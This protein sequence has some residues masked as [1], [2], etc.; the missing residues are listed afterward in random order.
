[1]SN[2]SSKSN[3]QAVLAGLVIPIAMVIGLGLFGISMPLVGT[4]RLSL[5]HVVTQAV[6]TY[7]LGLVA[8]SVLA[9]I[10]D[11]LAPTFGGTSNRLQALKVAAYGAT[12]GWIGGLF[13]IIPSLAVLG[14]LAGL[15]SLYLLW[16]GLPIVMKAP[17]EKSLGY[18]ATVVVSAIVLFVAI[19][20]VTATVVSTPAA[21]ISG[22]ED[23]ESS[24]TLEE[25]AKQLESLGLEPAAA[26]QLEE[27]AKQAEALT[28]NPELLKQ[29][30]NS[31][32]QMESLT[33]TLEQQAGQAQPAGESGAASDG[34]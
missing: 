6:M 8:V 9:W 29:L 25:A 16:V 7:A 19:G 34:R 20:A 17:S 14:M 24:K 10:I 2:N 27:A 11:L 33:K 28:K 21:L 5:S 22:G 4:V 15:Y 26:K 13:Q 30:E 12:A 32:Q 31:A 1:M 23:K 3:I 18:T